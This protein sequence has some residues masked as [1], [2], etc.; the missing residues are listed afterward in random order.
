MAEVALAIA[1]LRLAALPVLKKLHANAST[2]LGVNMAREIHELETTIMPQFELVIEAADKGNHRPKLDKWLQELKESFYLAEDLLDEHEYNILKHKAKGKDSMPANGSS[3]SNTFMKPLRSASSRLSN[4][5]SENRK[6]V[7]HLKEL[8]ATL[9]KAKDFHQLLC[10]PAG[11]NAERPA[12]PSD[13]VPEIT[14]LPPMKVIG[15]DKDRDHIIEC[16][17]KVTATTESSTTMYSGLAIVGVGGMGKS[18][19]AQL[20]Y[21]DKRVKE[22]FDVTMWVSIS[23]KLDVRRHTREII[24]SASKGECPRID[25][26]DTLQCKLTDILQESGKFLLVLDDVWFELGSERE[27]DQ[28]LAPLVSRQTGSKVLVTSRRDTFP[29]TL[30][31][32]VCPLEKMDDAQFLA[33]F[34]HHAFSGPEIR[35]PQLREKLEEFSK[36]IAKRLGQSPLAA[37]V[38]GSQ[39]KGKTD[40]TAWKDALTMKIDKLSDPMRALLW[41]YEKL[42]PCLQRCFLYCSLFPKGHKYVIDDLV[43]LWMAE[44]LVDS[45]NQNKRVEVVGRDCFHEMISVSFFQPV[46]EKYTDTYYVM[47]DLLHDLAES[48]SKEDYFRLEDDKVTEIPSTVRHLSVRVESMTQH[49]QSICKLHHLRTIICIDPLVDDVSDLFNQILQNLK[50]LRVLY[51]SSYSS[52]QLPESVGELKH[53][54]YLNIIG[55]LISE[56]PRSLCT[57]YHL[58]SLLLNDSVKSLPEN[59]CNLRKLRHL[60]RDELAL[61]QIPNIGKLTLLQQLD[62]FSVQKK[63]GFELEQLRDM[64]EIRGHLSVEHLENVT[65]KDQAIES[66]LY[67]KSHLDSLHLGWNL[68]NNTTAEDSLHLEIL[69]GL[70]PPPQISAL[71]IEGYESWKYPGWLIDGS[72]FENLNYLRFFGCRKLQILPSNTELFVNCTSLLLQGLSNLNTLPCLPLGLKVLKVQRCPL[73]IFISHDELEHNDQREN[74]TRTNHLASQLGLMWEVD[75][76]SGISTVLLSECSF[77]K[78]LMIFTHADMSHVQNFESALQRAKNGVLVK[79]DIIKAWICCHE[80]SMRLMYERRIGLPLVPPSGLHELHLSSCSITDEA[81]AVCLDGL[82]SLG[83]LFLEKIFNL[84]K[85]PS[86]EVLKH[87]AKLGHLNITDC[88]C[89]RSLGGLRAATSLAHFTLRSCPS[90]EL[91]HG[92]ECLPLS[93]ESLWIEKCMLEGNFLCTDWPH[94]DKISIW[95]CRSTACLSVGSLTSVKKLSLDRLP[96]LCM[97]EGLCFLQLE[98][99]GL[100]DVP[101][102]TLECTSQFRVRYKLAVS[103]PI[104]LNNMLSAEGFTVPAHLSLEGCEEP[105]ISF[106]ESANFTSVNRLEFSNCEMISLPTNLKCFSTLQNLMIC[107][108]YNISS[109]PDLPSSL[110][111]IEI[112]ACSDRLMESCQAPDGESWPKIAHIRWKTFV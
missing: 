61:P 110:Q 34:K 48:L 76:G 46:D 26:L 24:E 93:I 17:T 85:L 7:R 40:I 54:R 79:E 105:F 75:S 8:K 29:A 42:D 51:L 45:C 41:S 31:C 12:I 103:S 52:S 39:L 68:G 101:K 36:K 71:S 77:L 104:I 65:G 43:H 27:W 22:Y 20:V 21:N 73:L 88:W 91:A 10:L 33:L 4:L 28:L 49:K 23:R 11:H 44:G 30:C 83:S 72:Y 58:Q 25:N 78:Q 99:M 89:L 82:A 53:L 35:N 111:H 32:E 9:A 60:E 112:I 2:Y 70:T 19:L 37:K 15:R 92:A 100:I 14:S 86:E 59:I 47:H 18:T 96:D 55:T 13:V 74:S 109:L 90:L 108:C 94:M 106:D 64:N 1:A 67:Q 98:E 84:T 62:K 56:L 57:L 107:E 63:K 102:L 5:S 66:K 97:L 6:L 50:K 16:L 95:N 80:Q 3:I 69:E 81:L 38:M 87:L